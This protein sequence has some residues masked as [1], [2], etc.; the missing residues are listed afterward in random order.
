[1]NKSF[2]DT[3][4]QEIKVNKIKEIKLTSKLN[5]SIENLKNQKRPVFRAKSREPDNGYYSFEKGKKRSLSI[6]TDGNSYF[7][8]NRENHNS[9]VYQDDSNDNIQ[10]KSYKEEDPQVYF[11]SDVKSI[12][13]LGASNKNLPYTRNREYSGFSSEFGHSSQGSF[14]RKRPLKEKSQNKRDKSPIESKKSIEITAVGDS[15]KKKELKLSNKFSNRNLSAYNP[16]QKPSLLR[17]NFLNRTPVV[18]RDSQNEISQHKASVSP[19]NP[20]SH[21]IENPQN[22]QN[23]QM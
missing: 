21:P 17:K 12:I 2:V 8:R 22:S 20:P 16:R 10:I 4:G 1:M 3:D 19:L 23:S 14:Q 7:Q 18:Q 11:K 15:T 5:T 13:G 9:F 6:R